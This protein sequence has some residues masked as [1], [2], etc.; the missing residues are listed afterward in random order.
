[1]KSLI[2]LVN[3]GT[4]ESVKRSHVRA[5]LRK[6]LSD[7]RVIEMPCILRYLLVYLIIA[8]FRAKKSSNM[9]KKVWTEKGSPILLNTIL[10]Q[11]KL[12]SKLGASGDVW[13]AMRYSKP[14]I[15]QTVEA[16]IDRGYQKIV[17]IPLFP[18]YASST[19][20]TVIESFMKHLKTKYSIPGL[21]IISKFYD[22]PEYIRAISRKILDADQAS[23]EMILFSFHGLPL[24]SL[25]KSHSGSSCEE[26]ACKNGVSD[27][28]ALCYQAQCYETAK[29]IAKEINLDANRFQVCFQSR[30]SNHWTR[31][32]TDEVIKEAAKTG[33]KRILV[34]CPSFV[35][36]CLETLYEIEQEYAAMFREH[37]GTEL[38][39]VPALNDSDEWVE[40]LSG[41]VNE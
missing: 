24:K 33:T 21:K 14:N 16:V 35:I 34:V 13:F 28:N 40:A 8:P 18:Q 25:K 6:F 7:G 4:P 23:F 39:L 12:K 5:F 11:E 30:F 29:L 15:K 19:T 32:F 41:I 26:A 17:L 36:D 9:Y 20:G 2:I 27:K 10:L 38:K 3:V 1:M 37:G 22:R 31:P